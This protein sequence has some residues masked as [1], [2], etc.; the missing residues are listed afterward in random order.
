MSL[1]KNA[2]EMT[3]IVHFTGILDKIKEYRWLPILKL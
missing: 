1:K 2:G 3:I